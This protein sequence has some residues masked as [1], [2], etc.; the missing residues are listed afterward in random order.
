MIWKVIISY[1][2]PV[3]G[4]DKVHVL[5]FP[6]IAAFYNIEITMLNWIADTIQAAFLP[7]RKLE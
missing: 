3:Q 4:T 5:K 6:H 7:G 1:S 2:S